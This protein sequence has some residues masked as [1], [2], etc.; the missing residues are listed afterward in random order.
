MEGEPL[1][2][3]T[4]RLAAS[5]AKAVVRDEAGFRPCSF[6]FFFYEADAE[7]LMKYLSFCSQARDS[8]LSLSLVCVCSL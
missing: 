4:R 6:F 8:F 7:P 5:L 3:E 1:D 2:T